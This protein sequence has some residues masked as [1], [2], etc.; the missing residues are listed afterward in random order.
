M[1]LVIITNLDKLEVG[2]KINKGE[3]IYKS[4]SYDEDNN[5]CYGKNVT[6]MYLMDNDTIED[7]IKVSKSL[8]DSLLNTEVET[9]S[10]SLND[11]DI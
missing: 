2:D 10:V 3:V 9:V 11:N 5:Y 1:V 4:T 7:A 8:A 6:F